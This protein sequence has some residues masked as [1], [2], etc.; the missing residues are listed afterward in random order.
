MGTEEPPGFR[1]TSSP[2]LQEL[3]TA[4]EVEADDGKFAQAFTLGAGA[5]I[6][7]AGLGGVAGQPG[8]HFEVGGLEGREDEAGEE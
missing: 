2:Q 1:D 5:A 6:L 8:P 7:G 4:M 3:P